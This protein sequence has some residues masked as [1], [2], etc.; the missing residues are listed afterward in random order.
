[1]A[2]GAGCLAV[3]G[4]GCV[5]EVE[6]LVLG[7]LAIVG[8]ESAVQVAHGVAGGE[9][10]DDVAVVGALPALPALLADGVLLGV[11]VCATA[12][13]LEALLDEPLVLA[14][15]KGSWYAP[16]GTA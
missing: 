7:P 15:R 9:G 11:T 14:L 10:P 3:V 12:A 8:A 4:A 5:A 13:V 16:W 6:V 1:M 2:T